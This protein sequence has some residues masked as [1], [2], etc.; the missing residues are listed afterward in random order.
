MNLEI[1]AI[2]KSLRS[3]HKYTQEQLSA[4]LGV[5]PQAVSRWEAGN[6]YPDIELLP[7][8]ARFFEVSTDELLGLDRTEREKRRD[9]ILLD[10]QKHAET[11]AADPETLQT[12]RHYAAEF[13]SDERIQM[14]VADTLCRMHMW[15]DRPSLDA[16][17][18]AE[19][20]Y[21]TLAD[22]T[23][24]DEFRYEVLESLA[25]LYAVG[26]KDAF[27]VEQ[28]LRRLPTM[29]YCRESVAS[30]MSNMMKSDPAPAQDYIEK[31]TASLASALERY[32]VDRIPNGPERWD[33]KVMMLENVISLYHFVFG[34]DLVYYHAN[35]AVLYRIIATYRIAQKRYDDA[36]DCLEHMC[37]HLQADSRVKAGDTFTSPFTDAMSYP[38]QVQPFG[39]FHTLLAHN[40]A[41]YV[42]HDKLPRE[43]YD[44]IRETPQFQKIVK[45]LTEIAE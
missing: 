18:E 27:R 19:K 15:E 39:T 17:E 44:P 40:S 6:G 4:F 38:E 2:I 41:W 21:L 20:L 1:G 32:I 11:G 12:A 13:P 31:L 34:D 7:A 3:K 14:H 33:E 8:I 43:R 23:Q 25:A 16:L 42:L 36:L 37:V 5:T 26:Y 29:K 30:S 9:E 24:D 28:V 22:T 10:I 45:A 35:A